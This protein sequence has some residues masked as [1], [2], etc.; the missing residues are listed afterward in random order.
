MQKVELTYR[1]PIAKVVDGKPVIDW[2]E[3]KETFIV[4]STKSR[5]NL[6]DELTLAGKTPTEIKATDLFLD[7]KTVTEKVNKIIDELVTDSDE[8]KGIKGHFI[9]AMNSICLFKKENDNDKRKKNK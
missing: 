8:N 2:K 7:E 9:K 4:V 6:V 5:N 1:E 3:T